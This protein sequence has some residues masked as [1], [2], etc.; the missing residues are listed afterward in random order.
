MGV[1]VLGAVGVVLDGDEGEIALGQAVLLHVKAR[2]HPREAG[3]G[4]AHVVLRFGVGHRGDDVVAS[5]PDTVRMISPAATRTT[6]A[7][8]EA[9][10]M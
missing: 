6:S 1:V 9:M 10:A 3:Q 8:P 2:E 7:M 4:E 5:Q